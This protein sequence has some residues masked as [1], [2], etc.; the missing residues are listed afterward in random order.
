MFEVF[1]VK[2]DIAMSTPLDP[3]GFILFLAQLMKLLSMGKIY[4]FISCTLKYAALSD[5]FGHST[6]VILTQPY[7]TMIHAQD[8]D[9]RRHQKII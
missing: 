8:H 6:T 1:R 4:Y 3:Q 2:L 5:L 9:C 7:T